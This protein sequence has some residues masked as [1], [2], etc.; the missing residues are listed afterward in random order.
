ML[1]S[2]P[3]QTVLTVFLFLSLF[4]AE[5]WILGNAPASSDPVMFG[6]LTVIFVVFCFEIVVQSLVREKYLGSFFFYMDVLGT[7]SII[8]DIGW[9]ANAF[10]PSGSLTQQGQVLRATRAAKLGARYARLLRLLKVLQ[11]MVYYAHRGD[12]LEAEPTMSSVRKISNQL[13]TTLATQV[14]V[15][16]LL[17]VIV[18]PF[19]SYNY[20]DYS[21]A[22][23]VISASTLVLDSFNSSYSADPTAFQTHGPSFV[24]LSQLD[25]LAAQ[26]QHFYSNTDVHVHR[27]YLDT[28]WLANQSSYSHIYTTRAQLRTDNIQTTQT[29]YSFPVSFASPSGQV[30]SPQTLYVV[31]LSLDMTVPNQQNAMYG[32]ILIVIVIFLLF[33]FSGSFNYFVSQLVIAPLE[34]MMNTIR[35]SATKIIKSMKEVDNERRREEEQR[36]GGA[37]GAPEDDDRDTI[38]S[39]DNLET[40]LLEKIVEKCKCVCLV[41]LAV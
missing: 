27:V 2:T 13:S 23:W 5:S 4:L 25:G 31:S 18:V 11:H 6:I 41:C 30:V 32:I 12:V 28:P 3:V 37:D 21:P 8:L 38:D 7:F 33:A 35:S 29:T 24:T 34:K 10:L 14:A 40:E 16:V 15:L 9:I 19:L 1:D 26:I 39:E 36:E 22:A 20:V 17:L